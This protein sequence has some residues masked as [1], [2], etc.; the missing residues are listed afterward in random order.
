MKLGLTK[1]RLNMLKKN[2]GHVKE[3]LAI[4]FCYADVNCRFQVK[5][6][7]SKQE[8]IFYS[9]YDELHDIIDCEH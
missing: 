1:S 8:N 6:H 9:N 4:N 7:D 2:N 5:F 3:I